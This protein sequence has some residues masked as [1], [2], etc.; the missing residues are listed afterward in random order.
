MS[1]N[2]ELRARRPE[3]GRVRGMSVDD[4][5]DVGSGAIDALVQHGLEV[6][7]RIGVSERDDV[8]RL[9]LVEGHTLSLDPDDTLGVA[10]ADVAEG[11][12]GITLESND[13]AG[14]GDLFAQALRDR[15]HSRRSVGGYSGCG[16][17]N[18][19]TTSSAPV[20]ATACHTPAGMCSASPVRNGMASS[21]S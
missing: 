6:E 9:D 12:I 13:P 7:S 15:D 8:A 18:T 1:Q 10:R 19:I 2:L 14:P 16:K 11:E 20:L 17:P 4:R 3:G 5:T 21:S